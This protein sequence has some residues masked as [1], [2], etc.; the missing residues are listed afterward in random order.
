MWQRIRRPWPDTR[1]ERLLGAVSLLTCACVVAMIAFVLVRA[2]PT[3]AHEGLSWLGPGGSVDNQLSTQFN[4]GPNPSAAV[5]HLRAWPLLWGTILTTSLA[6]IIA[7]PLALLSSIFIV[8]FAPNVL[9]R[10]TIPVVR[11]LAAVPSVIYGLVGIL[12]LVPL[13][14]NN[15]VTPSEKA[16]HPNVVLNGE[17]LAVA[18]VVLAVMI[19]P[20]MVALIAEALASVPSSWREGAAALGV[21]KLRA[22]MAVSLRAIRPAIVAAA[23][24]A[25]A[26]AQGE[27]V[28]ISMVSGSRSYA[29]NLGQ[30]PIALLEPV[31]TLAS[32]ILDYSEGL[33]GAPAL[34]SS[35]YAFAAVLLFSAVVL[36][37]GAY[38]IKLPMR[39]YQVRG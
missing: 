1:A 25:C 26:R 15:I 35:L 9:R 36:S 30:G 27:A 33:G 29:P 13:V 5:Y 37:L 6:L 31:R 18:S 11:L 32:A 7:V 38:L 16:A 2:W 20:I 24:L 8:E 4:S 39:K 17:S 10:V 19:T 34:N 28:M 23:A 14:G 12:V 22:T 21:H 3:F